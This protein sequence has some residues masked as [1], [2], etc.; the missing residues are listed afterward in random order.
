MSR[1]LPA[2]HQSRPILRSHIAAFLAVPALLSACGELPEHETAEPGAAI[3]H[4]T[5]A[6][7]F[8]GVAELNAAVVASNGNIAL[9][10]RPYLFNGIQELHAWFMDPNGDMITPAYRVSLNNGMSKS[11][12]SVVAGADGKFLLVYLQEN[13]SG[14]RTVQAVVLRL[15]GPNQGIVAKSTFALEPAQNGFAPQHPRATFASDRG[16]FFV[17]Y[18]NQ[19][20]DLIGDQI[21]G[22]FVDANGVRDTD[23]IVV[24]TV[25]AA[26]NLERTLNDLAEPEVAYA[27]SSGVILVTAEA[28]GGGAEFIVAATIPR[29]ASAAQTPM[30]LAQMDAAGTFFNKTSGRFG[31][32]M[33]D[34]F[35]SGGIN[36]ATLAATCATSNPS[37]CQKQQSA[38]NIVRPRYPNGGFR[39]IAAAPFGAGMMV[40]TAQTEFVGA[41]RS[42]IDHFFFDSGFQLVTTRALYWNLAFSTGSIA[43]LT[44]G[45][46]TVASSSIRQS[47]GPFTEYLIASPPGVYVR[48]SSF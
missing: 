31:V 10:V 35:T 39:T 42:F 13:S 20:S 38:T 40:M 48:Q 21:E 14:T 15:P 6:Q 18:T 33:I 4:R 5:G 11:S 34:D 24:A 29:A 8:E 17:T 27:P 25:A 16:K 12:P 30:L 41:E 45:T 7:F 36:L 22:R 19:S 37:S 46:R 47:N 23:R 3:E 26:R 2:S 28:R 44:T 9:W 1:P 32:A 43:E